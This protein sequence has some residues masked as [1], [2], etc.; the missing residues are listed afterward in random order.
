MKM[1]GMFAAAEEW[2]AQ[3]QPRE[4]VMLKGGAA[5]VLIV[6]LSA[7]LTPGL[8]RSTQLEQRYQVLQADLAWLAQQQPT[9]S[10]LGDRCSATAVQSGGG[11]DLITRIVRRNQIQLTSFQDNPPRAKAEQNQEAF[12]LGLET[13]DANRLLRMTHQLACQGLIVDVVDISRSE[14]SENGYVARMEV[15]YGG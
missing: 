4:R 12:A 8:E 5:I 2:F 13:D 15:H 9:V 11:K 14:G 7:A 6:G 10:R 1:Q 3:L